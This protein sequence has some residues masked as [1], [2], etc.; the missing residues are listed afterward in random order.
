[1]EKVKLSDTWAVLHILSYTSLVFILFWSKTD[2]LIKLKVYTILAFNI[3]KEVIRML[4]YLL[5]T[6]AWG[7]CHVRSGRSFGGT[8]GIDCLPE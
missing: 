2:I 6:V 4:L 8:V 3:S 5:L 7:G 1:M